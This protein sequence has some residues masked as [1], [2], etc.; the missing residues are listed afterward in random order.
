MERRT[1]KPRGTNR[2]LYLKSEPTEEWEKTW[3]RCFTTCMPC[4]YYQDT[5]ALLT[6]LV[7]GKPQGRLSTLPED[8]IEN[9]RPESIQSPPQQSL[10]PS[11]TPVYQDELSNLTRLWLFIPRQRVCFHPHPLCLAFGANC[12]APLFIS[13]AESKLLSFI[14]FV[15]GADYKLQSSNVCVAL[16]QHEPR[17]VAGSKLSY[18]GNSL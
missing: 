16:W 4:T 5:S 8:L 6:R 2:H 12:K 7:G 10:S 17:W 3:F 9:A 18:L 11:P 14:L 13:G 15:C 1:Y